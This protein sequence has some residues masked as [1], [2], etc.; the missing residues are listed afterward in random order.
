MGNRETRE[1]HQVLWLNSLFNLKTAIEPQI[2][3]HGRR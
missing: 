2:N 3:D 1:K